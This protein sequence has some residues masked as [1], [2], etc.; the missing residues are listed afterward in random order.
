VSVQFLT[1]Y[2]ADDPFRRRQPPP[3][4][5]ETPSDDD[6]DAP[7]YEIDRVVDKRTR[8][9][10]DEFLVQWKGYGAKD[11]TWLTRAD[12]RHAAQALQTF[13]DAWTRQNAV[14]AANRHPGTT[15]RR[16]RDEPAPLN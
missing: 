1:R 3:G 7:H 6:G 8:R 14:R 11:N 10:K 15:G 12:L 2:H 4:P 5:V 16:P 9:G 13:E